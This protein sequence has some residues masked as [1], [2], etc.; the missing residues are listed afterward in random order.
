MSAFRRVFESGTGARQGAGPWRSLQQS[1]L[2]LP[3]GLAFRLLEGAAF[4]RVFAPRR[5]TLESAALRVLE[6]A[7]L[8]VMEW[9]A[10]RSGG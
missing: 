4:R 8:S 9:T 7:A 10:R 2:A 6:K 5:D 1:A 3:D